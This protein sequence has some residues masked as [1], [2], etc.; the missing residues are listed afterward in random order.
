MKIAIILG[1][2]P[3]IIK[4]SPIIRRCEKQGINYYI[5]HTGQ[6]YSYE[7]DKIFFEQ[8]K[9][10]Q[11]KYNLDVGS[12]KHGKQTGKM[13]AAIEEKWEGVDLS[14]ENKM[15][16]LIPKGFAHSYSVLNETA[17][18]SYKYE[19]Y[20]H[21]EA[22]AGIIYNDPILNVDWKISEKDVKLSEKEKL[23]PELK[24]H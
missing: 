23:L 9:L 7:M 21:P 19:E 2:R 17:V 11:A 4:M 22:E 20:Y 10:P 14:D 6:H 18:F 1:T 13:L 24:K 8:L 5:L 16:F 3:E 15:Q 12:G